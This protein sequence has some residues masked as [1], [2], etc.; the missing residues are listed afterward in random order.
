MD[1]THAQVYAH[2]NVLSD[3]TV[4]AG[5]TFNNTEEGSTQPQ[6][7]YDD[8]GYCII[9]GTDAGLMIPTEDGWYEITSFEQLRYFERLVNAGSTGIKGR[10]MNDVDMDNRRFNPIG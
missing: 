10:L 2:G 3:G 6:H 9:C 8:N 4:E 1:A 7:S 5:T